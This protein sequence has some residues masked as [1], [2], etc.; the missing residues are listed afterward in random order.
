LGPVRGAFVAV[1]RQGTFERLSPFTSVTDAAG[2]FYLPFVPPNEPFTVRA[3]DP[4]T[5]AVAEADGV[6]AGLNV[7]T[8]VQLVFGAP[9]AGGLSAAFTVTPWTPPGTFRFDN[10]P[11]NDPQQAIAV[12][13][14][15][16]GTGLPPIVTDGASLEFTFLRAGPTTVSLSILDAASQEA[17]TSQRVVDV[18]LADPYVA[19]RP[20]RMVESPFGG[21]SYAISGDGRYVAFHSSAPDLVPGDTNGRSDVFLYDRTTGTIERVSLAADGSEVS[22]FDFQEPAISADGRYVAYTQRFSLFDVPADQVVV[23]DRETGALQTFLPQGGLAGVTQPALSAD[24]RTLVFQSTQSS[25]TSSDA[26]LHAA[27]LDTGALTWVSE[28]FVP[29]RAAGSPSVSADGRRVA[30]AALDLDGSGQRTGDGIFVRDLDTGVTVRASES[31]AGVAAVAGHRRPAISADGRL[32]AFDSTAT[33]LVDDD[34][35]GESDVFLKDL[36][37]GAVELLSSNATGMQAQE[38][39]YGPSISGDG[40]WVAFGS[41]AF[42]FFPLDSVSCVTQCNPAFSTRGFSFVKDRATGWVALLTIGLGDELPNE[43]DQTDPRISADGRYVVFRS[44]STNLHPESSQIE[45][46]TYWVENPLWRPG[47]E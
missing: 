10:A 40:R 6:S 1:F 43:G 22:G 17:A 3:V 19:G 36:V 4:A 45:F 35:N 33:D 9:R 27:D 2:Y 39:S 38:D 15:D 21:P 13:A 34:L 31:A 28:G 37:T 25:N 24:G 41:Y 5:G 29:G 23:R 46:V 11:F 30:F 16:V 26:L 42:E 20:T 7:L 47:G 8:P 18:V 44:R 32:V 12:R 14:W